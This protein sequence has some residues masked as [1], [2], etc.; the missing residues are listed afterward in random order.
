MDKRLQKIVD[1]AQVEFGLDTYRLERYGIYKQRNSKGEG[2]YQFNMEWFPKEFSA[3]IEEDTNPDGTVSIDYNIQDERFES[4]VFVQGQSFATKTQFVEKTPEEVA[5]WVE[6]QTGWTY[7]E[8]FKL[9][10]ANGNE[11]Q[12][13]FDVD[14]IRL[15]SGFSITVKFDEAGKLTYFATYG[16]P[17]QQKD[18]DKSDYSLTL[19]EIEQLVKQ[20]LQLVKFPSE[21]EMRFIPTYAMEEVFVTVD[22]SRTI[23]FFEHERSEVIVDEVMNWESPLE[24]E[25]KRQQIDFTSVANVEDAFENV[26]LEKLQLTAEQIDQ[27]KKIV[28]DV[29]RTEYPDESGKWTLYKIQRQEYFIEV[30]CKINEGI[31]S[32]FQRKLVVLID[33][34]QMSVLNYM[35]NGAMFEIFES[36]EHAEEVKVTHE[37]AFEK[38]I[39]YITLDPTYVYDV[40]TGKYILCGLLDAAEA[41]DAVTGEIIQLSDL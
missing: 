3:G 4:V 37:E 32:L 31:T 16:S 18:I 11:F 34:E 2:Y 27:G 12:F 24:I 28:V 15:S 21:A 6:Q 26:G 36:F 1:E 22:G 14:G 8:D 29:L 5:A 35:D 39:P 23:P 25:I 38:M 7:F 20:Q 17:P 19:E 13:E 40:L 33:P 10:Q 41:V 30:H 9:V